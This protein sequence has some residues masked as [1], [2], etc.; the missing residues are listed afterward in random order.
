MTLVEYKTDWLGGACPA[1]ALGRLADGRP[2]YFR[3]R[4]G[5]WSLEVRPPEVDSNDDWHG[6]VHPG[7][8]DL[9]WAVAEGEDPTNGRMPEEADRELLEE[10]LGGL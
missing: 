4:H 3:A 1:Q 5:Q 9:V 7:T 2:L 8:Q 6:F 10:H